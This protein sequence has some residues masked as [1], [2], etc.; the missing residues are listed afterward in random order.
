MVICG[1]FNAKG[2]QYQRRINTFKCFF[3][4]FAVRIGH[5]YGLYGNR[6]A[7]YS[8]LLSSTRGVNFVLKNSQDGRII[9]P[10]VEPV[11][12]N[13][14]SWRSRY[15]KEDFLMSENFQLKSYEN[16]RPRKYRNKG[17]GTV[18]HFPASSTLIISQNA[19]SYANWK[20]REMNF[21]QVEIQIQ[22]FAHFAYYLKMWF[23]FAIKL[24]YFFILSSSCRNIDK[25][26]AEKTHWNKKYEYARRICAT[27]IIIF[28]GIASCWLI[29]TPRSVSCKINFSKFFVAFLQYYNPLRVKYYFFYVFRSEKAFVKRSKYNLMPAANPRRTM[30]FCSKFFDEWEPI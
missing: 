20:E 12:L 18:A 6:D 4:L 15:I 2:V 16:T 5:Y 28:F 17:N 10:K 7:T 29:T 22:A 21:N 1:A 24:L 26:N 14:P 25:L 23:F 27:F 3:K 13:M 30:R 8:L 11:I 9:S 19:T